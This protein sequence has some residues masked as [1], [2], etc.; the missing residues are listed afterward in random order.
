MSRLLAAG[1]I[2]GLLLVDPACGPWEG[3]TDIGCINGIMLT[4]TRA[5]P[6]SIT[7][8]AV[9]NDGSQRSVTCTGSCTLVALEAFSPADA[10][11]QISWTGGSRSVTVHPTYADSRPNG[12]HCPP[13]CHTAN[14][15]VDL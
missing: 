7:V 10:T 2:A 12:P 15:T 11:I 13:I 1:A 9:G 14:V 8:D 3:C 4:L 5:I 6:P